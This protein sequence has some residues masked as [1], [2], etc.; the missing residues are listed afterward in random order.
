MN[1]PIQDMLETLITNDCPY[2]EP[3]LPIIAIVGPT[4]SGKSE[5]AQCVAVQLDGEVVSADSMQVYR[6]MDIGTAKVPQS[7]RKVPHHLIDIVEPGVTF[8]AQLFQQ[9]ARRAF[10]EIE[11]RNKVPILCGGT[12]FY[13][14]AALE[15]MHF[16]DGEQDNNPLRDSLEAFRIEKGNDALWEILAHKDPR[17][18]TLIHPNNYKRVIRAL[19]MHDEG[20]SYAEQVKNIRTLPE[21]VPS[22]RFFL[23]IDPL[24][25]V[26][27]IEAR[28]DN[29]KDSGLVEEVDSLCER[30]FESALTAP[31]AIGYKEIIAAKKGLISID[32]AFVKIKT[33]TRRYAKRQRS[34]FRRDKR[35][36]M[37]DADKLS[38]EEMTNIVCDRY[39][40]EVSRS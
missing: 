37:L 28:V 3:L 12:G 6:F 19:E 16:P 10:R 39:R 8:S 36:I 26:E 13:V 32:E 5:L 27:R 34:W 38:V 22:L 23:K 4:A 18:A 30:G 15:D 21:A 31:Q 24:K 33:A 25:L 9:E 7:D 29:M 35:L 2:E 20:I 1:V 17:S 11:A 40:A 14:Q